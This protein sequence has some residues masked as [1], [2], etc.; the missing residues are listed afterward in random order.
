M[1]LPEARPNRPRELLASGSEPLLNPHATSSART[2]LPPRV[3]PTLR[4]SC[5]AVPPSVWPAGAQGGTSACSTGAALS[6]VSCIALFD[7]LALLLAFRTHRAASFAFVQDS[8]PRSVPNGSFLRA[9]GN[10]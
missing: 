4:I 7:S 1:A 2:Q 6:F 9:V 8:T 5:E 3:G 10:S